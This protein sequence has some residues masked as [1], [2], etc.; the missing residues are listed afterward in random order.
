MDTGAVISDKSLLRSRSSLKSILKRHYR[1][2][3]RNSNLISNSFSDDLL[4]FRFGIWSVWSSLSVLERHVDTIF[5]TLMSA[6]QSDDKNFKNYR[7]KLF[8]IKLLYYI[9][10]WFMLLHC[11]NMNIFILNLIYN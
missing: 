1:F 7:Q 8:Y 10:P 6:D 5:I 11:K 2:Q 3:Q 4:L 9:N